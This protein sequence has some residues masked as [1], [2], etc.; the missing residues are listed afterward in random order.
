[1]A[2]TPKREAILIVDDDPSARNL[3]RVFLSKKGYV[4]DT[5]DGAGRASEML[6]NKSYDLVLSDMVMKDTGGLELLEEINERFSGIPFI[7]MTAYASLETAIKTLGMGASDYLQ[8][9]LHHDELLVK[10]KN[11][12][13]IAEIQCQ[14]KVAKR[15]KDE[16]LEQLKHLNNDLERR[17]EERTI[18]LR[19]ANEQLRRE[20]EERKRAE[21]RFQRY[22]DKLRV[23]ASRLS[24]AEE[25]ERRRMAI[26]VHD[27]IGQN[28]AF[29]KIKLGVIRASTTAPNLGDLRAALD[30]V[31]EL[32]EKTVHDTR[33]L[34]SELASPI[35]YELGLAPAVEWLT[36]QTQ[37]QHGIS[38]KFEN[39]GRPIPVT[40]DVRVL[41]YQAVRELL[42]NMAKHSRARTG[43]VS[44]M[45][46]D[47]QICIEVEDDGIGFDT[48]KLG[49]RVDETG[50]FGLFSIKE[51]LGPLGGHMKIESEPSCGTRVTLRVPLVQNS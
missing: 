19:A 22:Y 36:Q 32:V 37:R 29:A 49:A 35:L 7:L 6:N 18:D 16:L 42:V 45:R 40:D 3:L 13:E 50:G 30:E 5:A 10:I 31:S 38:L 46:D 15:E 23:M 8:K 28:L 9:P 2:K 17:V 20:M 21:E 11:A 43:K 39:D 1:M 14:R 48:D 27:R 51:R 12:L 33:S 26:E 47:R 4:V 44:V 24:L 34:T 25:R 41:M